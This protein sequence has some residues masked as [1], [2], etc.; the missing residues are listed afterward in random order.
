LNQRKSLW[1]G[2]SALVG[3]AFA[4]MAA[5]AYR[6]QIEPHHRVAEKRPIRLPHLSPALDGFPIAFNV[7]PPSVSVH[8]RKLLEQAVEQSNALHPDLILLGGDYVCADVESI[9]EPFKHSNS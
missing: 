1:L 3:S 2:G 8:P 4:C 5:G 7:R 9:R 6:N